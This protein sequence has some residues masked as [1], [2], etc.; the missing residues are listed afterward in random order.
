MNKIT[1]CI[2]GIDSLEQIIKD[3]NSIINLSVKSLEVE[4]KRLKELKKE[5]GIKKR[6]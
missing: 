1:E 2:K 5:N 3:A 6:K 4:K